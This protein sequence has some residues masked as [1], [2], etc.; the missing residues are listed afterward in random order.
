MTNFGYQDENSEMAFGVCKSSGCL[1]LN[2]P[3][4]VR[5]SM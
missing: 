1:L 2:A 4:V 5:S 3:N